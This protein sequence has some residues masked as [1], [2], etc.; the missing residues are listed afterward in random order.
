MVSFTGYCGV[1]PGVAKVM[2]WKSFEFRS[3][4]AIS[5]LIFRTFTGFTTFTGI[6]VLFGAFEFTLCCSEPLPAS[7][8]AKG[9][10]WWCGKFKLNTRFPT[11]SYNY[12]N[13]I[14]SWPQRTLVIWRLINGQVFKGQV[15]NHAN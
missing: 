4:E 8:L 5:D 7:P 2:E 11:L 15:Q 3:K 1:L 12:E 14:A 9:R 6:L 13:L 10:C